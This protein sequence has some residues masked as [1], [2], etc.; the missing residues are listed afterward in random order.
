MSGDRLPP[1]IGLAACGAVLLTT[2]VPYLTV[3]PRGVS[4]YYRFT[5]V[6]PILVAAVAALAAITLAAGLAGYL[7]PS[8]VAGA[9]LVTGIAMVLAAVYWAVLVPSSIVMELSRT[10]ALR[11]HRWLLVLFAMLVAVV[12]VWYASSVTA[13]PSPGT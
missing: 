8:V 6:G 13:R 7:S 5:L 1:A 3:P 9:T 10:E 11:Y 12:G 4:A 2:V